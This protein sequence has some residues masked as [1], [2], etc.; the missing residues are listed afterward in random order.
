MNK[1]KYIIKLEKIET[2]YEI[3]TILLFALGFV[4]IVVSSWL[5]SLSSFLFMF[6]FG[7]QKRRIM[8]KVICI[9]KELGK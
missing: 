6:I 4:F 2:Y 7:T 9:K 3:G 5:A 1:E 8:K